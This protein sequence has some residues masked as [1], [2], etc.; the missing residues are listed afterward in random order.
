MKVGDVAAMLRV[1]EQ[2]VRVWC[3]TGV[4]P[5]YRPVGTKK[6]LIDPDE[7][8]TWL[9]KRP[10]R[11]VLDSLQADYR[12]DEPDHK[13]VEKSDQALDADAEDETFEQDVALA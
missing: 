3:R 13:L 6:W 7:F 10:V 2:A 8:N 4:L 12:S 11:N 9:E 5:A 1:S